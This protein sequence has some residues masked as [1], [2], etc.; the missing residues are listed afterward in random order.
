LPFNAPFAE[1]DQSRGRGAQS[2][3]PGIPCP[4]SMVSLPCLSFSHDG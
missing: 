1:L 4:Q 2:L 3:E